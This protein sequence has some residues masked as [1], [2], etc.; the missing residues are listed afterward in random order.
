MPQKQASSTEDESTT[1]SESTEHNVSSDDESGTESVDFSPQAAL[2]SV[3]TAEGEDESGEIETDVFDD[4][5]RGI[6]SQLRRTIPYVTAS[7]GLVRLGIGFSDIFFRASLGLS[8]VNLAFIP[9]Y[10]MADALSFYGIHREKKNSLN[11][12]LSDIEDPHLTEET[13]LTSKDWNKLTIA[14]A[15]ILL[16]TMAD[17]G[18]LIPA[19]LTLSGVIMPSNVPKYIEGGASFFSGGSAIVG[20]L[21]SRLFIGVAK[22]KAIIAYARTAKELDQITGQRDQVTGQLDQVTGQLDQV[23][24][25]RDQVTGQ[26]DQ[27]TGQRD[28]VTGQLDQVTGLLR[29]MVED[30]LSRK[31]HEEIVTKIVNADGESRQFL[32]SA[33]QSSLT[34]RLEINPAQFVEDSNH[35]LL[36]AS[37][38][39]IRSTFQTMFE[40]MHLTP[41]VQEQLIDMS[42]LPGVP[43][44][45][46]D[47]HLS[48][49][50]DQRDDTDTTADLPELH[51]ETDTPSWDAFE[52]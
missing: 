52:L 34:A 24:G 4:I 51:S 50:E 12:R 19:V 36:S 37:Q 7:A 22:D 17:I 32:I 35:I 27:V 38:T 1:D 6:A 33:L 28:Q 39:D 30:M 26:L 48:D 10:A 3:A 43:Q 9:L 15:I 14:K 47:H 20:A 11:I 16:T 45:T 21:F 5:P 46:G 8:I 18:I 42:Q 25:Q 31:R 44:D 41:P 23:T 40:G 13:R 29:S 49:D 2:S